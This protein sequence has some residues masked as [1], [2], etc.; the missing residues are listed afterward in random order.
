M[1]YQKTL[2]ELTLIA[3]ALLTNNAQASF[4]GPTD[5]LNW[6]L[7]K[8]I[9]SSDARVDLSQAP[10][11]FTLYGSNSGTGR[12]SS[13]T[14]SIPLSHI[15]NLT[16]SSLLFPEPPPQ[17]F[18]IVIGSYE[19]TLQ[20]TNISFDWAYKTDD[21]DGPAFDSL[22]CTPACNGFS[23]SGASSQFGHAEAIFSDS[24]KMY[25]TGY[26]DYL[27]QDDPYYY[28]YS[29]HLP[30]LYSSFPYYTSLLIK[31]TSTDS[32]FGGGQVTLSNFSITTT[33]Q[34]VSGQIVATPVPVPAPLPTAFWLFTSGLGLLSFTR[35]KKQKS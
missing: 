35:R 6:T 20:T 31:I 25:Q 17:L 22:S 30:Y 18:P 28:F 34:N 3:S 33:F 10:N 1:K 9:N 5:L 32:M 24:L 27:H 29:Y 15:S 21:L 26:L 4:I 19:A 16:T 8:S 7:T 14:F 12:A 2:A 23:N 13:D 11:S